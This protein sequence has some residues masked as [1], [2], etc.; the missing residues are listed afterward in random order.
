M[1]NE[2]EDFEFCQD[3]EKLAEAFGRDF[4]D[5]L[6]AKKES[7]QLKL[8]LSTFEGQFHVINGLLMSKMLFSECTRLEKVWLS[9]KFHKTKN[10]CSER[11]FVLC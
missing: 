7:S 8:G 1:L 3:S 9:K 11:S 6:E 4:S 2:K 5:K 10:Y